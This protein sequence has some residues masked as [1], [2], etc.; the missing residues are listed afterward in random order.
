MSILLSFCIFV[1]FVAVVSII[2]LERIVSRDD[3]ECP[4]DIIPYNCSIQSNSETVHLTWRVTIPGQTP[5]Y[6][7]YYNATDNDTSLNDYITT[8]VT[9]FESDRYI[10]STLKI[11]VYRGISMDQIMLECSINELG[12]ESTTL[13]HVNTSSECQH[14]TFMLYFT[15]LRT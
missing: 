7:T 8:S 4:G 10:H 1:S 11:T 2:P 12:N 9:G 14:T 5:V 13:V 3:I 15:I 6:I